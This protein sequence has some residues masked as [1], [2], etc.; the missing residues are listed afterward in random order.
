MSGLRAGRNAAVP[1]GI[2]SW[3]AQRLPPQDLTNLQA[4]EKFP[5]DKINK[6]DIL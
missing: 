3:F 4:G 5:I 1:D 6:I 2:I